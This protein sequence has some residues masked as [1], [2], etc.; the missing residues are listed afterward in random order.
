MNEVIDTSAVEL[1]DAG[2]VVTRQQTWWERP[3]VIE[4]YEKHGF[5]MTPDTL[6]KR[7][8]FLR[9]NCKTFKFPRNSTRFHKSDIAHLLALEDLIQEC[10]GLQQ[11]KRQLNEPNGDGLPTYK[12]KEYL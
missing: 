1:N 9:D 3:E 8:K 6:T 4:V 10:G 7:I 5:K 11:A 2:E 12:Y